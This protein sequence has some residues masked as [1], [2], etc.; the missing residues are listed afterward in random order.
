MCVLL[1]VATVKTQA[2]SSDSSSEKS[3]TISGTVIDAT[4]NQPL[5]YVN[6]IVKNEAGETITGGI[7]N[8]D[9]TFKIGDIPEGEKLCK[10][11]IHWF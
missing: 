6:V 7:S 3:G 9:G 1:L 8:D 5:P 2:A 10:H 11:S 4:L